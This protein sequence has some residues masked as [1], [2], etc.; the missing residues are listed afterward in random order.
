VEWVRYQRSAGLAARHVQGN[1]IGENICIGIGDKAFLSVSDAD[2]LQRR[3][4]DIEDFGEARRS[5]V[6]RPQS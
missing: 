6:D 1:A 2:A 3:A 5:N 4:I